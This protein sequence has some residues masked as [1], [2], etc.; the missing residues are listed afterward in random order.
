MVNNKNKI[1]ELLK[2]WKTPI[3][4][5]DIAE[6]LGISRT[7]VWKNIQNL[8]SMGYKISTSS[9]GYI[10]EIAIDILAAPE[11]SSHNI[12][13]EFYKTTNSTMLEARIL[14]ERGK[15]WH[16]QIIVAQEQ[17]KGIGVSSSDFPS[18]PGG[19]Y[20]NL[21]LKPE[22]NYK[23]L[24]YYPMAAL[25]AI[26]KTLTNM[27]ISC[28]SKNP[29]ETFID[30]KKASGILIDANLE[31]WVIKWISLGIG[32]NALLPVPRKEVIIKLIREINCQLENI[33]DILAKYNSITRSLNE[34]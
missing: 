30:S 25:I 5:E 7:A 15:D 4:G 17:T 9:K 24:D 28:I 23:Y 21:I 31:S 12:T 3:S 20:F 10:L 1:L 26:N 18:P 32:I 34:A 27:G 14:R 16:G 6:Q 33:D 11:F 2:I 19:I 29:F 22:T 13:G 8:I